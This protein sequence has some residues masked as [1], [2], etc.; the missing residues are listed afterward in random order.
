MH[1]VIMAALF[2]TLTA[3][4][5]RTEDA[6]ARCEA[7]N[8]RLQVEAAELRKEGASHAAT[9][10][11]L[12]RMLALAE[13][14]LAALPLLTNVRENRMPLP[15]SAVG[16]PGTRRAPVGQPTGE[17]AVPDEVD[18]DLATNRAGVRRKRQS[19]VGMARGQAK[20]NTRALPQRAKSFFVVRAPGGADGV[21]HATVP[22][23]LSDL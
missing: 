18:A 3:N 23:S 12:T 9:V 15:S 6:C 16:L 17:P 7:E 19:S 2:C 8:R 13:A 11:D 4:G 10:A 21:Q 5:A 1:R 20:I 14:K 22:R